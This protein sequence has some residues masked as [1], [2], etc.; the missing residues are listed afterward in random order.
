MRVLRRFAAD[1]DDRVRAVAADAL[2]YK[3]M[4]L[5]AIAE[6]AAEDTGVREIE[7]EIACYDEAVARYG[8]D[9]SIYLKRAVAEALLH[10]AETLMEAGRSGEASQGLDRVIAAYAAIK[11]KDLEEIVKDARELK[12]EI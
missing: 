9:N 2:M 10:K 3:G 8:A 5:G 11:D 12:A 4:S 7:S 1:E 6:D